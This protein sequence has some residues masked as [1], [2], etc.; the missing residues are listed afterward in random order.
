[1]RVAIYTDNDF[2]KV[3]GVTTTLQA[4]LRW[5]PSDIEP[6]I[7][8]SADVG[9]DRPDYLA[10]RSIGMDVPFYRGMKMYLPR[11]LAFLKRARRDGIELVH[12][13]TPGPVG[14]AAMFT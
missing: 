13:T 12:Y 10:L 1:M 2:G 3:N 8:T 6:R 9:V 14:L 11:F 4:V 7:Y 5:H